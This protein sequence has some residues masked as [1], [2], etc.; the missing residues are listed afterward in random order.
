MWEYWYA[1]QCVHYKYAHI[2]LYSLGPWADHDIIVYM[3]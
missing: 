3:Y 2:M 1:I